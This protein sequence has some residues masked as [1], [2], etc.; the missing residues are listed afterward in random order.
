MRVAPAAAGGH[1]QVAASEAVLEPFQ[2]AERVEP[3]V[4]PALRSDH[5]PL[6]GRGQEGPGSLTHV[7]PLL[8][9]DGLE[10][11]ECLGHGAARV[12]RRELDRLQECGQEATH[13]AVAGPQ[14]LEVVI[15]GR[16]DQVG[17]LG[18]GLGELVPG[19]AGE[20]GVADATVGTSGVEQDE[21]CL[22]EQQRGAV[23]VLE[24][25]EASPLAGVFDAGEHRG[26]QLVEQVHDVVE[27]RGLLNLGEGQEGRVAAGWWHPGD[28]LRPCRGGDTGPG[29]GP[30]RAARST[31]R[32]GPPPGPGSPGAAASASTRPATLTRV[33]ARRSRSRGDCREL[34]SATSN[35]SRRAACRGFR[36]RARVRHNREA[37]W[38]RT[39]A[40]RRAS[41]VTPG[42]RSALVQAHHRLHAH[43][44][45]RDCTLSR[46]GAKNPAFKTR[47][48]MQKC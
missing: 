20:D 12:G 31:G 37:A 45:I 7:G 35:V 9:L 17:D 39:W 29:P 10:E 4:D 46:R 32:C 33:G 5:D 21:A 48:V 19:D 36:A 14:V 43:G 18:H 8:P 44:M 24:R 11:A 13:L 3:A 38:S 34:S 15:V 42:S 23:Q 6:P 22:V 26:D 1:E 27:G 2:D 30:A 28:G 47:D 41:T 25:A 40:T 16:P